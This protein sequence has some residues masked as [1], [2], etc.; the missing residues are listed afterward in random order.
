MLTLLL[1]RG[2]FGVLVEDIGQVLFYFRVYGLLSGLK[3]FT[4]YFIKFFAVCTA[5]SLVPV[6][7]FTFLN[8]V[9][10]GISRTSTTKLSKV[11][12]ADLSIPL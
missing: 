5:K 4:N 3:E 6:F 1:E 7:S 9:C 12:H 11:K 10:F 8:L 2:F